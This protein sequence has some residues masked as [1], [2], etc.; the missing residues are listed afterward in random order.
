MH[1]Q[2]WIGLVARE[3]MVERTNRWLR[4]EYIENS[5]TEVPCCSLDNDDGVDVDVSF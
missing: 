2:L 1:Q 5:N 3:S 4:I